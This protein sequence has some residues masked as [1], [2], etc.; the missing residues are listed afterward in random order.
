MKDLTTSDWFVDEYNES[1]EV[2]FNDGKEIQT[3]NEDGVVNRYKISVDGEKEVTL[4]N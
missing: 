3:F 2:T 4:D 1:V